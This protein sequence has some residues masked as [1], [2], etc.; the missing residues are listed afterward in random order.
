MRV[1]TSGANGAFEHGAL[2][3]GEYFLAAVSA[4]QPG[5]WR[6]A[7]FLSRAATVAKRLVLDWGETRRLDLTPVQVPQP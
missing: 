5:D 4:G 3:A 7:A 2:P 6:T 1:V